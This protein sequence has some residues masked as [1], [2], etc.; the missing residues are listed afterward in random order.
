MNSYV[1]YVI[2]QAIQSK[3]LNRFTFEYEL[4]YKYKFYNLGNCSS[5]SQYVSYY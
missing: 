2:T 5:V 3:Y 4:R 1:F